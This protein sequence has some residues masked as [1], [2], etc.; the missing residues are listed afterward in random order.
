MNGPASP[1][2]TPVQQAGFWHRAVARA[3]DMLVTA[4]LASV[5]SMVAGAIAIFMTAGSLESMDPFYT[6]FGLLLVPVLVVVARYEVVYVARRGQTFGMGLAGI[7]VVR[8]E[9]P[10]APSGE[11]RLCDLRRS[12]LRWAIPHGAGLLV[13]FVALQ[14]AIPRIKY[15]G[16]YVGVGAGVVAWALVFASSLFGADGRGWHDKAA[17]TIVVQAPRQDEPTQGREIPQK[18]QGWRSVPFS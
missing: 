14:A 16:G 4:V 3:I 10:G 1:E 18:W 13:G 9:D 15:Y 6:A 11:S 17:G 5:L 8:Y 7:R 2:P 12:I